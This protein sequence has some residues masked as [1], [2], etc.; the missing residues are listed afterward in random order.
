[1][2]NTDF[3]TQDEMGRLF[4]ELVAAGEVQINEKGQM[5]PAEESP[6][7]HLERAIARMMTLDP[8]MLV[9]MAD[10]VA[11]RTMGFRDVLDL[12]DDANRRQQRELLDD[13]SPAVPEIDM[14]FEARGEF[15]VSA[16]GSIGDPPLNPYLDG[17]FAGTGMTLLGGPGGVGKTWVML[18]A[19]IEAAEAASWSYSSAVYIDADCNG[20]SRLYQRC[21]MLGMSDEAMQTRSVDIVD[22]A[23][24][25]SEHRIGAFDA[26]RGIV[27][28]LEANPPRMIV[29]DS[30]AKTVAAM[31]GSENDS[32]DAN[33]VFA[34]F[35]VLRA[36][37][38]VIV[39]DHVGHEMVMRP[40]G[41]AAKIDTPDAVV[42]LGPTGGE[43]DDEAVIAAGAVTAVKDRHGSLIHHL[44]KG[45]SMGGNAPLGEITVRKG[46]PYRVELRSA[47]DAARAADVSDMVN[48]VNG[49]DLDSRRKQHLVDS[50]CEV[51]GQ[52]TS[53]TELVSALT[54]P[55]EENADL[56]LPR[57][58]A[59]EFVNT[60]CDEL[61]ADGKAQWRPVGNG[62]R[63]RWL[64]EE[65][66]FPSYGPTQRIDDDGSL[67]PQAAVDPT[68]QAEVA[69][70]GPLD[71]P[72]PF[73]D[74]WATAAN[75]IE[76]RTE[77]A[78]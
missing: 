21:R 42:M 51:G 72:D 26:L 75:R 29:L 54:D 38:S 65:V 16:L 23:A 20:E 48:R 71:F 40:R 70:P 5:A 50:I 69:D 44:A 8:D 13:D 10:R 62:R 31:N 28:A 59:R 73:A 66:D 41:A 76:N 57:D 3:T 4:S 9:A 78:S 1:M 18:A 49:V 47:L 12:V 39:I 68:P 58:K 11:D 15:D 32:V 14:S 34:L 33:K 77:V 2:T 22:P 27:H 45:P 53:P 63:I 46:D 17:L 60:L 67:T 35:E 52:S 30:F 74:P 56:K 55:G 64:V 19:C 7:N 6:C 61:V 24:V 36:K 43:C 25:A 37:C